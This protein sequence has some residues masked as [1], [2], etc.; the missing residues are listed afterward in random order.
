[1]SGGMCHCRRARLAPVEVGTTQRLEVELG[2]PHCDQ[3]SR[4]QGHGAR[5]ARSI[6]RHEITAFQ[7]GN[8][9][10]VALLRIIN[11]VG[12]LFRRNG[13]ITEIER[14]ALGRRA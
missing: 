2:L 6:Q 3:V 13:V 12:L 1:M 11:Q 4:L 14:N 9:Q 10:E 7:V 8:D 5:D